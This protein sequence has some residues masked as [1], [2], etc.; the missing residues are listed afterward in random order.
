M[1]PRAKQ[2]A[3]GKYPVGY[4]RPPEKSRFQK[5]SSGNPSGRPKKTPSLS[6]RIRKE[7]LSRQT[8][9]VGGQRLSLSTE[10]VLIK[11]IIQHAIRGKNSKAVELVLEW[12]LDLQIVDAEKAKK[13]PQT[14][15]FEFTR[16]EIKKMTVAEQEQLYLRTLAEMNRTAYDS[17]R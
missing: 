11:S 10:E 8:V 13:L 3:D 7:L 17:D 15:P 1:K 5:G 4:K 6:D 12:I 14:S 9:N 16:E 2:S